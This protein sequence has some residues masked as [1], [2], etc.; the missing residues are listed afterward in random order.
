MRQCTQISI[1]H[2]SNPAVQG[3]K[4]VSYIQ[5]TRLCMWQLVVISHISGL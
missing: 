3:N 2:K 5:A 1:I 4:I